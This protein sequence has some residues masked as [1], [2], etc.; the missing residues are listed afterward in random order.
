M[1]TVGSAIVCNRLRLYGNRSLRSSA[2]YDPR[3]SA[4]VCDHMETSLKCCNLHDLFNIFLDNGVMNTPKRRI[5]SLVFTVLCFKQFYNGESFTTYH[6]VLQAFTA[7]IETNETE[8]TGNRS[9]M[10]QNTPVACFH[11]V[12]ASRNWD[13]VHDLF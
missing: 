5:L 13:K 10:D 1:A 12:V 11:V 9:S 2:I 3:S 8:K 4:I 6:S 7:C